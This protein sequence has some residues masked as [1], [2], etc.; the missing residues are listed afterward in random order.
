MTIEPWAALVG[1][2]EP[3]ERRAL[4]VKSLAELVQRFD[5]CGIG[6]PESL[7][8]AAGWLGAALI[9]ALGPERAAQALSD[10]AADIRA[11]AVNVPE[12]NVAGV[13]RA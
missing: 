11:R 1:A 5:A 8:C 13:G 3:A 7:A 9:D 10:Q 12:P 2:L 6:R 4:I